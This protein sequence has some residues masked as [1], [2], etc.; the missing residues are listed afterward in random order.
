MNYLK[1]LAMKK[2]ITAFLFASLIT[3]VG[4]VT[5]LTGLKKYE[6]VVKGKSFEEI[7]ALWPIWL[8]LF[9]TSFALIYYLVSRKGK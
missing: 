2:T 5:E 4:I 7:Y 9:L 6:T 8:L 1:G 3:F